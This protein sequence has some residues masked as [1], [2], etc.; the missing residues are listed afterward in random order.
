MDKREV[1]IDLGRDLDEATAFVRRFG[2]EACAAVLVADGLALVERDENGTE[3]KRPVQAVV[4][5]HCGDSAG[6]VSGSV[7]EVR[8]KILDAMAGAVDAAANFQ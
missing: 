2:V 3:R 6:C 1:A 4:R 7:E 5:V 8:S